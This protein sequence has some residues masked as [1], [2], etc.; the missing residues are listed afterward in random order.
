VEF[1]QTLKVELTTGLLK[2]FHKIEREATLPNS[3]C[4]ASSTLIPKTG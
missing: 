4:E 2:L 3:F 1:Y